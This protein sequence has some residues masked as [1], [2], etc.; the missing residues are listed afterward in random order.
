MT[1]KTKKFL[2]AEERAMSVLIGAGVIVDKKRHIQIYPI[3]IKMT[4]KIAKAGGMLDS[5]TEEAI[6]GEGE[7]AK[8]QVVPVWKTRWLEKHDFEKERKKCKKFRTKGAKG[9]PKEG[10]AAKP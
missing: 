2:S 7:N 8:V 6:V 3:G 1:T 10:V 5:I 9:Q 4:D